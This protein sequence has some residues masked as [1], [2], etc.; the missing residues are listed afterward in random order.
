MFH[1][2]VSSSL[3]ITDNGKI[4]LKDIIDIG[5][6]DVSLTLMASKMKKDIAAT[7]VKDVKVAD[8]SE[9]LQVN[10]ELFDMRKN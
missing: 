6:V 3:I 7:I 1:V 5:M 8:D 4:A 10:Q 2:S 9:V